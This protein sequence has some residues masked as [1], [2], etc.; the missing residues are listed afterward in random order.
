MEVSSS[1]SHLN[2][3]PSFTE[4]KGVGSAFGVF[5]SAVMD[6]VSEQ[7]NPLGTLKDFLDKKEFNDHFMQAKEALANEERAAAG[8]S[9]E[10]TKDTKQKNKRRCVF[11]IITE[12]QAIQENIDSGTYNVS[13]RKTIANASAV[14]L[15]NVLD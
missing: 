2:A 4:E 10:I 15:Y 6:K 8:Y 9:K 5:Q 7:S 11:V 3:I 14:I 1:V 12:A 13:K